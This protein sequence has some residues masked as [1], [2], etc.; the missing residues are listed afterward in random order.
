MSNFNAKS[1]QSSFSNI[2][3]NK[4]PTLVSGVAFWF[5][6]G[7]SMKRLESYTGYTCKNGEVTAIKGLGHFV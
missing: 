1:Q 5:S 2:Y 3:R 4:T 6:E 7:V